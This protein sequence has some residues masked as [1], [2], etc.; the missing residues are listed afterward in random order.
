MFSAQTDLHSNKERHVVR[1]PLDTE[2]NF[3]ST[4]LSSQIS[5]SDICLDILDACN[6]RHKKIHKISINGAFRSKDVAYTHVC[7][8]AYITV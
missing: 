2:M 6:I 1:I 5:D 3:H 7:M 8:L 4:H